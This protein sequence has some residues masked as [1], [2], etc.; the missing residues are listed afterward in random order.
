MRRRLTWPQSPPAIRRLGYLFGHPEPAPEVAKLFR[1]TFAVTLAK[2]GW[3]EGRNLRVERVFNDGGAERLPALVA[4]LIRRNVEVI[5]VVQTATAVAAARA[6][7]TIPIVL[8]GASAYPVECGLIKSLARPGT[9]V[10]GMAWFPGIEVNFKLAEL[11]REVIPSAK[12][13]AWLTFPP[14]LVTVSGGYFRPEV[15]Y[16]QVARKLGFD[17]AHFECSSAADIE[18]VYRSITAWRPSAVIV[19]PANLSYWEAR[20]LAVLATRAKLPNLY[21]ITH[22]VVQGGLMGYSP[23][24][25]EQWETGHAYVDRIFHG[26]TPSEMPVAM[27]R[28]LVLSVNAGAAKALEITIP[29]SI[30]ARVDRLIE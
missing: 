21:G 24:L 30:L 17:F 8:G 5:Y 22:N 13:L 26:A 9:N 20:R 2:L 7:K 27:P 4:E 3:V 14:D 11:V 15:Y 6:T 18:P 25:R 10:T 1:E 23:V 12:R 19:E 29:K 28:K 16:A